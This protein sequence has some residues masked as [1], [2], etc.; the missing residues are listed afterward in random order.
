[1]EKVKPIISKTL[2]AF[3]LISIGFLLGKHSVRQTKTNQINDHAQSNYV[4]VYYLHSTFRCVTCNT[5][6][7]MTRNLLENSYKEALASGMIQWQEIDFQ[8]NEMIAKKFGVIASCVVVAAVKNG[9]ISN[10]KR[11]DEV[12]TLMQDTQKFNLYISGAIDAY[13]SAAGGQ[14]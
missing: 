2:I 5:I 14:S 8:E 1:M 3:V 7:K 9:E 10:F 11:L 13:L 4:K 6:E 12:W